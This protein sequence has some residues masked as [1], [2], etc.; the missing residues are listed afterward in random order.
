MGYHT[1]FEGQFNLDRPLTPEHKN[2]LKAFS[3]IRHMT[4]NAEL[5][6]QMED[7]PIRKAVNLPIGEDGRYFTGSIAIRGKCVGHPALA[8]LTLAV[9]LPPVPHAGYNFPPPGVPSFWCQWE[10][11]S[12]GTAIQWDGIEKFGNYI[13]W[14]RFL[15]EHFL[16]P[17]G[18]TLNGQVHW[19]GENEG[20]E[21]ILIVINNQITKQAID[22]GQ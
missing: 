21:G 14:L 22:Q 6:E 11:N 9:G 7:D 20:D 15:L 12:D 4:W 8:S 1:S 3:E 2:Y 18:Y 17:W 13:R 19:K 10:P 16:I 5:L